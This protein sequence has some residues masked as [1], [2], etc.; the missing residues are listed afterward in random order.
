MS[1]EFKNNNN[2]VLLAI[3]GWVDSCV[4]LDM[5]LKQDV[6]VVLAHFNHNTRGIENDKDVELIKKLAVKNNLQLFT[7]KTPITPKSEE[8]ARDLRYEFLY[9]IKNKICADV[10]ALAQHENDQV[11]TCLLQL[12]RGT[13]SFSPMQEFSQNYKWRPLLNFSKEEILS[14]AKE[15]N[16][17][18]REDLSNQNSKFSRNRIRNNILEEILKINS[19]FNN[20]FLKFVNNIYSE[21]QFIK[22]LILNFN[23]EVF[24][25]KLF[26]ELPVILQKALIKKI[27]PELYSKHI[28]EVI[29]LIKK[30]DWG[31]EKHGIQLLK[32]NICLKK[33]F[34]NLILASQ[35]PQRKK[36]LKWMGY[37]FQIIPSNYEEVWD[38]KKTIEE[39]IK[40]FAE[41]KALDVFKDFTNKTVIGCDTFVVHPKL[42]VFLK[43]KNKEE[44]RKMLSSYS[45]STVK[46]LS[47]I[48]VMKKDK[49]D[50]RLVETEVVFTKIP[51]DKID[52]WLLQDEWQGRSG[53]CSIEGA[54]M[55]FVKKI[56]WC[57]F[58]IIGLP[59]QVLEE[60]L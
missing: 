49:I 27:K 8:E 58:N 25:R 3:S 40:Y 26:L 39:N 50:T 11:E 43:P 10:I 29:N 21:S 51:E 36:L 12:I 32:W 38:D 42:W 54:A 14:Y 59:T 2:L 48:T 24:N 28:D 56:E 19:N 53:A 57:F 41:Q 22:E 23:E 46:V 6:K 5:L 31:K 52:W 37:D 45:N 7:D 47:G 34:S 13:K 55:R 18:W 30:W 9:K 60:M 33:D 1:Y 35:S 15:N 44:A 17:K 16:L 4:L 20:V